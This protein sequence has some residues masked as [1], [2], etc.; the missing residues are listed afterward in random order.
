MDAVFEKKIYILKLKRKLASFVACSKSY[1]IE[2]GLLM[3]AVNVH[4][5]FLPIIIFSYNFA[6]EFVI[7]VAFH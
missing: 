2:M 3:T 1:L 4:L 5:W 6:R 7:I